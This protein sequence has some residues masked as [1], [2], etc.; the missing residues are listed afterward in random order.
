[1]KALP[2]ALAPALLP[3]QPVWTAPG[4]SAPAAVAGDQIRLVAEF[5]SL[6]QW[7]EIRTQLLDT[8]GVENLEIS[9]VSARNADVLLQYPGGASALANA[10]GNRGLRLTDAGAGWT[11]RSTY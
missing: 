4:A 7:N 10:L 5:A 11:L 9:T 6:A 3:G 2:V 1:M 8:P